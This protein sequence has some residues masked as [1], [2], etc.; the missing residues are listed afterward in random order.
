MTTH[1]TYAEECASLLAIT[2]PQFD[3]TAPPD[4]PKLEQ[5][6]CFSFQVPCPS[7]AATTPLVVMVT[8]RDVTVEFLGAHSRFTNP[9]LAVTHIRKVIEESTVVDTWYSGPY[10]CGCSF[11]EA[12]RPPHAPSGAR[13]VTRVV[14]RSWKGTHDRNAHVV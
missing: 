2:F 14:R 7:A 12:D 1:K 8:E 9:Q 13:G 3:L 4:R 11:V 6:R 10:A 5:R